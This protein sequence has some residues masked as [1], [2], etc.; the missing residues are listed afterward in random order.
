MK[1]AHEPVLVEEIL[2]IFRNKKIEVFLDGTI[3]AGSH[4][5]EILAAH[6][7]IKKYIGLDQDMNAIALAEKNLF[8]WKDKVE[9]IYG[10]FSKLTEFLKTI[11]IKCLDGCLFDIGV[12]SMQLDN[13]ERGFSFRFDA[14]LDMRMD[15]NNPVTAKDIVN[16]FSEKK[17][18]EIFWEFGEEWQGK[19]AAREI[20]NYRK[21]H[22]IETTKQLADLLQKTLRRRKNIHPAT[23]VFQALRIYINDELENLKKG[24]LAGVDKLCSEGIFA[25]ISFHSLEDRI[26]KN[27]FRDKA[28]KVKSKEGIVTQDFKVLTKKPIVPTI[29]EKKK[30]PRSR[31]S[32]LRAIKKM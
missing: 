18:S 9:L 25:A 21:I 22:K 7:E 10:N 27:V 20:V 30:N 23:L 5:K 3:G 6:P 14:P 16:T 13:K 12:S 4:A 19:K 2:E 32:K 28:K 15:Q 11:Q 17:L 1:P 29:K 26:V 8:S 24:L 31:S